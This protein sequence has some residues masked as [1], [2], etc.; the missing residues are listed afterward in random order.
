MPVLL[1][2]AVGPGFLLLHLVYCLDRYER[3]PFRNLLRYL[4]LGG[5]APLPAVA[6]EYGIHRLFGGADILALFD[7]PLRVLGSLFVGVGLIEEGA[8]FLVLYLLA[9][10]DR[11]L[12]EPFDWVVYA[13][14]VAL[15]FATIENLCYVLDPGAGGVTTGLWRAALAV[16]GH[17][18]FGT[19]MGY[20]LARAQMLGGAAGLREKVLA[21]VEPAL[22]HA[23]YDTLAAAGVAASRQGRPILGVALTV[24]FFVLVAGLWVLGARRVRRAQAW[25]GAHRRLPF[26]FAPRDRWNPRVLS[27]ATS[28]GYPV[29]PGAERAGTSTSAEGGTVEALE[30]TVESEG[31]PPLS[32]RP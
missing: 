6:A 17:A 5:L 22:W 11:D 1:V 4:A 15:G 21:V 19:L 16:P 3:E 30:P 2:L 14:T 29:R 26:L 18:L 31:D 28:S 12:D 20:R 10:R 13:V 25:S 32:E 9:V 8:K 7:A 24:A 27:G 23:V